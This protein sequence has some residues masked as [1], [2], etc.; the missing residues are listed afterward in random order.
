MYLCSLIFKKLIMENQI[1]T[2]PQISIQDATIGNWDGRTISITSNGEVT[3]EILG[4]KL[5]TIDDLQNLA[6][7]ILNTIET[8]N[9]K[10]RNL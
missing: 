10:F 3:T 6:Q 2:E 8:H 5:K 1:Q 4:Y 7:L 9:E